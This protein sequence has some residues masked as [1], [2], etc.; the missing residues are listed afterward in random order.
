VT[1]VVGARPPRDYESTWS[2]EAAASIVV[3]RAGNKFDQ[4]DSVDFSVPSRYTNY[5]PWYNYRHGIYNELKSESAKPE[6]ECELI[7]K[8]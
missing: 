3:S 1:L 7:V 4:P 2:K 8:V 5:H 6:C